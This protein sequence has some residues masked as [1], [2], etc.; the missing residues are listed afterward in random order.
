MKKAKKLGGV[1]AHVAVSSIKIGF[2]QQEQKFEG[3]LLMCPG[4]NLIDFF[5]R[6][7]LCC[8]GWAL[9]LCCMTALL[10]ISNML[11]LPLSFQAGGGVK[12]KKKEGRQRE[13]K[14]QS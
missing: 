6:V 11:Y 1:S 9:E 14:G 2:A 3:T 12:G 13:E 10:V 8:H 7:C 5:Y 4:T